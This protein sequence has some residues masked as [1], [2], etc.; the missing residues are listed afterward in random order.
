MSNKMRKVTL[1]LVVVILTL[2]LAA[3]AKEE[4][5]AKVDNV[6]ISREEF[7]DR[8]ISISGNEVLETLIAETLVD[9][10]VEKLDIEVP[11][12]EIDE[13]M[14]EL[15]NY[16]GGEEQLKNQMSNSGLTMEGLEEQIVRNLQIKQLVD[17]YIDITDEQVEAYYEANI[18]A[19][20]KP[21][22]VKAR[23]ILLETKEEADDIHAQLMD[24]GDF[25]ELAKEHSTDEGSGAQ[26]G[27]LGLFGRGQ[28]VAEFDEA[29]FS[30]EADEI[31]EPVESEFGFHIIKVEEK[32]EAV[33]ANL[34][35]MEDDIKTTLFDQQISTAYATWFAEKSEE[36]DIVN[37]L[38]LHEGQK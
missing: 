20:G 31:S 16:Y 3:C 10:E 7:Y 19:L 8:L 17:P 24:G 13:E 18:D 36:Y 21:E 34:E 4:I 26:G 6:K 14:A 35:D 29:V 30:M 32:V 37:Y 23:H 9:L 33:E 38:H 5:V 11:Q 1:L 27:D 12:E 15:E 25:E 22:Q 28:M 2:S